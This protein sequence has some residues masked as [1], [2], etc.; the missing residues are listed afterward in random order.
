MPRDQWIERHALSEVEY[1]YQAVRRGDRDSILTMIES[2]IDLDRA[3]GKRCL[4]EAAYRSGKRS[5]LEL[6]I[7]QSVNIDASAAAPMTISRSGKSAC[8]RCAV[9]SA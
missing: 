5:V 4:L 1:L 9:I 2:G 6:L 7:E 3:A 8:C